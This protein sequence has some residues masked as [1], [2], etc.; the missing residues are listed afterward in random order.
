[1]GYSTAE[2]VQS[3]NHSLLDSAESG[4]IT[5]AIKKA[6]GLI[7]GMLRKGY[8]VPLS[9]VP[10]SIAG[11]SA[12]LAASF[13]ISDIVGNTGSD[14]EPTQAKDLYNKSLDLLKLINKGDFVL[15]I[16]QAV[17][18]EE[19]SVQKQARC[20]TYN[21]VYHAMPKFPKS[22]NP[23]DPTTFVTADNEYNS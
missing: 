10:D 4:E 16:A 20:T 17:G 3:R 2:T 14:D 8:P 18:V 6:D 5:D 22:W 9:I 11:I 19:T 13:L 1:M 12:D 21:S 23:S 15:E 7:D